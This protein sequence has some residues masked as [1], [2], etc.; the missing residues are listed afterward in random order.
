MLQA[1]IRILCEAKPDR[2]KLIPYVEY[3][4]LENERATSDQWYFISHLSNACA[5]ED[6]HRTSAYAICLLGVGELQLE[7]D[8]FVQ[9][10][11]APAVLTIGPSA[12]R[13]FSDLGTNYDAKILF[14]RK[15]V[16]LKGQADINYLDKFSFF[17]RVGHQVHRLNDDQFRTLK[18][19]F[20]LIQGK[21]LGS[22]LLPDHTTSNNPDSSHADSIHVASNYADS[23]RPASNHD[24]SSHVASN[25]AALDRPA[26]DQE[27][28][29]HTAS[30]HAFSNLPTRPDK[31]TFPGPAVHHTEIVRSLINI[32]LNEIGD[33][34][35]RVGP[36][37]TGPGSGEE[38]KKG[39]HVLFQFKSLLSQH[40][41]EE[42]QVSFYA[43]K[44]HLTPKYFST[45]IKDVSGK[46]AGAWINEMLVLEARVRLQNPEQSIAQIAYELNFSDPSHFGRFFKKHVGVSP[47]EYR[48]K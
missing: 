29:S 23:D 15:E 33:I 3:T 16:F 24:A 14:F 45:L 6:A 8:L 9:T 10:V 17:D 5:A 44:L 37:L 30:D 46:T 18:T 7:T 35:Q 4:K 20:D 36:E 47:L 19:Y 42:R 25:Y 32:V 48:S 40:F 39:N 38:A 28:S 22:A 13:N 2:M 21:S 34:H 11:K 41:I 26:S 27:T 12:I 43:D 1:K 31:Q